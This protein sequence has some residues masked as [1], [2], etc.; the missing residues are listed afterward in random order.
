MLHRVF[1]V[2]FYGP[3]RITNALISFLIESRG[4]I[5]NISSVSGLITRCS[6]CII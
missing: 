4:R 5:V 2:K 6:R 1:N 3:L